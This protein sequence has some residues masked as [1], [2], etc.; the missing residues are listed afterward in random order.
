MPYACLYQFVKIFLQHLLT[1]SFS[2][3]QLLPLH[4]FHASILFIIFTPFDYQLMT[5]ISTYTFQWV[6]WTRDLEVAFTRLTEFGNLMLTNSSWCVWTAQKQSEKTL[7]NCWRKI[8]FAS[9]FAKFFANFWRVGSL[10]W[11][12]NDCQHVLLTIN[13]SKQALYSPDSQHGG[14][15]STLKKSIE[16]VLNCPAVRDVSSLA[17]KDTNCMFRQRLSHKCKSAHDNAEWY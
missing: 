5:E 1:K 3:K 7:A 11:R 10:L 15:K 12:V 13:Q 16:E 2:N 14:R 9:I 4:S 6:F 17:Y 8:E